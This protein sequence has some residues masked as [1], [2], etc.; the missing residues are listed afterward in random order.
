MVEQN[1]IAGI[2]AKGLAVVNRDPV[3]VELGL[4]VG[5][6]RIVGGPGAKRILVAAPHKGLS[7]QIGQITVLVLPEDTSGLGQGELTEQIRFRLRLERLKLHLGPQLL[8]P[9][10]KPAALKAGM[11]GQHGAASLPEGGIEHHPR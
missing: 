11:A 9:E 3:G 8:Q 5:A 4:S 7:L 2:H 10:Q 1:P 6:T